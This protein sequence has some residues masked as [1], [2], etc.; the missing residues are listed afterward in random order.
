MIDE[1]KLSKVFEGLESFDQANISETMKMV[2]QDSELK[3][4]VEERYLTLIRVLSNDEGATLDEFFHLFATNEKLKNVLTEVFY[5]RVNKIEFVYLDEDEA[6]DVIDI[7]GGIVA[8]HIDMNSYISSINKSRELADLGS[9]VYET[10][11]RLQQ[12]IDKEVNAYKDGWYG[13]ININMMKCILH[14]VNEFVILKSWLAKANQSP[15]I[16]AFNLFLS[17]ASKKDFIMIQMRSILDEALK[18]TEILWVFPHT[19]VIMYPS[20]EK[21]TYPTCGLSFN[22]SVRVVVVDNFYDE[23]GTCDLKR[24]VDTYGVQNVQAELQ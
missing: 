4:R 3:E 14:G 21:M 13:D 15:V 20:D 9:P 16:D 8:T 24:L 22:R 5:T 12:G 2:E 18:F 7:I 6:R 10:I 19:P 11:E 1:K 23:A 17:S